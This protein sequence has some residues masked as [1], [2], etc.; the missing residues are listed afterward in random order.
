MVNGGASKKLASK[1]PAVKFDKKKFHFGPRDQLYSIL[2]YDNGPTELKQNPAS[3]KPCDSTL[4][5]RP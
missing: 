3:D 1:T 2:K 5:I 4:V